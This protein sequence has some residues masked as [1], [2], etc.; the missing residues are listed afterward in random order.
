MV[1]S[2]WGEIKFKSNQ[3]DKIQSIL[4]FKSENVSTTTTQ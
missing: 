3:P 1:V 2:G 4:T